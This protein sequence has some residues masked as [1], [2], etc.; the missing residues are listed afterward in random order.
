ASV[1]SDPDVSKAV[2]YYIELG[3]FCQPP[4]D[5]DLGDT[6]LLRTCSLDLL[7]KYMARIKFRSS[8][9]EVRTTL[10]ELSEKLRSWTEPF[11]NLMVKSRMN[12]LQK[13][14]AAVKDL[15]V[16]WTA[17]LRYERW[18]ITGSDSGGRSS[19][20]PAVV[21]MP[22]IVGLARSSATMSSADKVKVEEICVLYLGILLQEHRLLESPTQTEKQIGNILSAFI[23]FGSL[24]TS[25]GNEESMIKSMS[26]TLADGVLRWP[27]NSYEIAIDL[28]CEH[29]R[30]GTHRKGEAPDC[31]PNLI[32]ILRLSEILL[33]N[34]PK[35]LSETARPLL[36][37]CLSSLAREP[38]VR[39]PT[40]TQ[41]CNASLYVAYETVK[42]LGIVTT[43]KASF[44]R[45]TEMGYILSLILT[46]LSPSQDINLQLQTDPPPPIPSA[47]ALYGNIT[48]LLTSL[49]RNV[50]STMA[51]HLADLTRILCVLLDSLK[52]YHSG[53]LVSINPNTTDTTPT[54]RSSTLGTQVQ[55]RVQASVPW[56][57]SVPEGNSH[58]TGVS[59]WRVLGE[60]DAR[61]LNR[62]LN[63]LT[64]KT[65]P[66]FAS[67]RKAGKQERSKALA[68]EFNRHAYFVIL[69]YVNAIID[70]RNTGSAGNGVTTIS[71]AMRQAIEEGM[72]DL[73]AM[74]TDQGRDWILNM[75]VDSMVSPPAQLAQESVKASLTSLWANL[76]S[77]RNLDNDTP[78]QCD[79]T[80]TALQSL[81]KQIDLEIIRQSHLRNATLPIHRLP[82][83]LF[84]QIL[85]LS[86]NFFDQD[87]WKIKLPDLQ[88]LAQVC[89][90]WC[91][92]ILG[93]PSF[94]PLLKDDH[95]ERV[96]NIVLKRN[97]TAPLILWTEVTSSDRR[98][99][100]L[101]MAVT[102]SHRWQIVIINGPYT[103][104][105]F[106]HLQKMPPS[107]KELFII[108]SSGTK[109]Q[110]F[111]LPEGEPLRHLDLAR[112]SLP[113]DS[114]R[115]TCLHTIFLEFL[116]ANLPSLSQLVTILSSSPSL[117]RLVLREW[118][119][120]APPDLTE[121][122]YKYKHTII[123]LP[124]LSS[125]VL[126]SL[127]SS[128]STFLLT[129]IDSS[130]CRSIISNA[131][132]PTQFTSSSSAFSSLVSPVLDRSTSLT[133]NYDDNDGMLRVESSPHAERC[134]HFIYWVNDTPGIDIT[135]SMSSGNPGRLEWKSPFEPLGS[136]STPISLTLQN[137]RNRKDDSTDNT[138]KGDDTIQQIP[139]EVLGALPH[140]VSLKMTSGFK[141]G[142]IL[143]YLGSPLS[144]MDG[145]LH[146]PCPELTTVI[147]ASVFDSDYDGMVEDVVAFVKQRYPPTPAETQDK[148]TDVAD[149][150]STK[151]TETSDVTQG[152]ASE[153]E[154]IGTFPEDRAAGDDLHDH[155][156]PSHPAAKLTSFSIPEQ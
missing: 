86:V 61:G 122:L 68:L 74:V 82:G 78:D 75:L 123:K 9:S 39:P 22:C 90:Y 156:T 147:L 149:P 77:A 92:T 45:D 25:Q 155:D 35:G 139:L 48:H 76:D 17:Y 146:W 27:T 33:L 62:V 66:R 70:H 38:L 84:I 101:E 142:P 133:L 58:N 132:N 100:F 71:K 57:V 69:A 2:K 140:A 20:Q 111:D 34:N 47:S 115:L 26:R 65:L 53:T 73:C 137:H 67:G 40:K 109:T 93:S 5:W 1:S 18:I 46:I 124:R 10:R 80:I 141:M 42:F 148:E 49:I 96:H 4:A 94:W 130:D 98:D 144:D 91:N 8:T 32:T 72:F 143:R 153:K 114:P 43:E 3:T 79:A 117:W 136:T 14:T 87:G 104:S 21:I 107:M 60:A 110:C 138:R 52:C 11:I 15:L 105:L 56:W 119:G 23:L 121:D 150:A 41:C 54:H 50:R 126:Q 55:L 151:E 95:G 103:D 97:P 12:K 154:A 16:A 116:D 112:V 134:N 129:H 125:L 64:V 24:T 37:E 28:V 85:R 135:F 83:E 88:R 102:H 6:T 128:L 120:D 51:T 13:P 131:V 113:W 89:T 44:I 108:L 36:L 127:P 59:D 19:L 31:G 99:T 30:S 152:R 29:L 7:E 145:T 118:T 63:A 106:P 81:K